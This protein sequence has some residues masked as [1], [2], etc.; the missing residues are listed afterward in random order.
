M[1][2]ARGV[3]PQLPAIALSDSVAACCAVSQTSHQKQDDDD[4]Y[5]HPD[6]AAWTVTPASAVRP[7]WQDANQDQ[8]QDDQQNCAQ[9]H[10]LLPDLVSGAKRTGSKRNNV[11]YRT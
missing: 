7:R 2:H 11:A 4:D 6:N 3:R 5:D 8:N 1:A 9:A 10:E